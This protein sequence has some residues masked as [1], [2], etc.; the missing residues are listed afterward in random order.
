VLKKIFIKNWVILFILFIAAFCR[1]YRIS[2]YMEFLGD[3]GRDVVIVRDFLKNG[4][5]F[6]IGPQ[7]S[8]GNMYLG[9]FYYYLI[10]P[11]LLLSGLSPVGP[12][13]FVALLNILTVY[14]LYQITKKWFNPQSA[15]I[16]SLL[17]AISPVVI[18]YSSFSWNPNIMPLFSLLF[19]YFLTEKKYLKASLAFIMC[20]NSHYLALLLLIPAFF[21]VVSKYK[22]TGFKPIIFA[23]IIFV[24]SLTPQ[25]LFDIKH[26]GQ[27]T[28]ALITFFSKR[29]TTVN[30]KAYKALPI[31]PQLYNQ[32]VTRL[33]AGKNETFG[34]I[35]S[36]CL[37]VLI[38]I[39]LIRRKQNYYFYISLIWFLSGLVGLA[40]YKQHIYDHYFGF[41]YPVIF[42]LVGLAISQLN[43][44]IIYLFLLLLIFFSLLQNPFRFSP[45]RQLQTTSQ[46]IDSINK[47]SNDNPFNFAL[48]AKMNYDPGYLYFIYETK[49]PYFH[50]REK[51][52]DQLFVVCEPFQI[53]CNPI[54]NPEWSVAA[55]GWAKI[56]KQWEINGIKIF[57]LIH[58]PSGQP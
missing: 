40:L 17:F 41:I 58:N 30:L 23:F 12:A 18:K 14:L 32:V 57:K 49:L 25:F 35:V 54:N 51:I 24:L 22:E 46:I 55:F 36:V 2:E 11:F 37:F 44:Y 53:E 6:F 33:V 47:E 50:L 7:T 5:L 21:I 20:L 9:P 26:Q 3:Q 13:V 4:N 16:S 19:I 15:A 38:T 27:N 34:T 52:T 31:L 45:P 39:L 8:I 42:I 1:L 48:L 43:K 28:N 56:D 10:A 29:E